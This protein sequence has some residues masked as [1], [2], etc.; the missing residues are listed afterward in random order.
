MCYCCRKLEKL[1]IFSE[2]LGGR[3]RP[4]SLIGS[5]RS[6]SQSGEHG[7]PQPPTAHSGRQWEAEFGL[8]HTRPPTFCHVICLSQSGSMASHSLPQDSDLRGQ[9]DSTRRGSMILRPVLLISQP[10]AFLCPVESDRP[11]RSDSRGRPCG[12]L[13]ESEVRIGLP[14]PPTASHAASQIGLSPQ[15]HVICQR[16]R[17][18]RPCWRPW[19]SDQTLPGEAVQSA[20]KSARLAGGGATVARSDSHSLPHGL[21]DRTL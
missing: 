16:V 13:W 7:L 9:S 21:T 18:V 10:H 1:V 20:M 11:L 5:D 3:G 6:L 12:R 2:F 4:W 19:E 15:S 8:S 14:R 17:S